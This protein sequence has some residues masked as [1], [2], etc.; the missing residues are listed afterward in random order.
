MSSKGK[1]YLKNKFKVEI[2]HINLPYGNIF[3]FTK[4]IPKLRE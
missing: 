2:E 3:N 1:E 4:Y